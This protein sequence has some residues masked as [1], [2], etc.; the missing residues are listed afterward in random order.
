MEIVSQK[1]NLMMV[2]H[3]LNVE[4]NLCYIWWIYYKKVLSECFISLFCDSLLIKKATNKNYKFAVYS[5]FKIY[6]KLHEL[7]NFLSYS[8]RALKS[9]YLLAVNKI[10]Q[11]VKKQ[12]KLFSDLKNALN[13]E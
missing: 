6:L 12:I 11:E 4:E 8:K 10:C 1:P 13:T 7:A 9:I 3:G 5:I 2:T